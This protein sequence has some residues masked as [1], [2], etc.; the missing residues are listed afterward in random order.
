MSNIIISARNISINVRN[1]NGEQVLGFN[2]PAYE[3]EI[4]PEGLLSLID[5]IDNI[6]KMFR[7]KKTEAKPTNDETPPKTDETYYM[8]LEGGI[9]AKTWDD[10]E[11]DRLNWKS[12]R[13]TK[14][15][16]KAAE[17]FKSLCVPS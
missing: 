5:N 12:G 7:P 13:A 6:D 16:N 10:H 17:M 8:V 15:I 4:A 1:N 14:D 3:L 9:D 2:M 11:L